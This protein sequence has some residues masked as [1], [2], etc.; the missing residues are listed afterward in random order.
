MGRSKEEASLY[1]I[2]TPYRK[3]NFF[4]KVMKQVDLFKNPAELTLNG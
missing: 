3:Q 1:D 2:N 4:S